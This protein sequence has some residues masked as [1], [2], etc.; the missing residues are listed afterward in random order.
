MVNADLRLFVEAWR[1]FRDLRFEIEAGRI[2]LE[3]PVAMKRAFPDWLMLSG[4][5]PYRRKRAGRERA[6]MESV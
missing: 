3:G 6:L 2:K 4:L 1:G 5:A